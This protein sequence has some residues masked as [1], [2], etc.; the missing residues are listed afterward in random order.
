[1]LTSTV[2]VAEL[3]ND[4]KLALIMLG[5]ALQSIDGRLEC[6]N[7]GAMLGSVLGEMMGMPLISIDGTPERS[8]D[9]VSH[10][11]TLGKSLESIAECCNV[12]AL[13]G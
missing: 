10:A 4:G 3:F 7:V 13:L 2:G 9:G 1:M 11:A 5:N 6:F 8:K 12:G